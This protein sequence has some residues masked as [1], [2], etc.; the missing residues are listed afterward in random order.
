MDNNKNKNKLILKASAGT[1]K[2]YRLSLEYVYNLCIGVNYKNILVMTFTK[3]ATAEIKERILEFL[4]DISFETKKSKDIEQKLKEFHS[5]INIDRE[6]LNVIYRE[7]IKNK[8]RLKIYT[9][10][11]FS[12][13]IFKDAIT[14]YLK[15]YDYE[16]IDD[17]ENEKIIEKVL[18]KLFKF[19]F[20]LVKEF[21][22]SKEEKYS[23]KYIN[24]LN[25]LIEDRWKYIMLKETLKVKE[26]KYPV[27][28]IIENKNLLDKFGMVLEVLHDIIE[29]KRKDYNESLSSDT[30]IR[31]CIDLY[32]TDG[33]DSKKHSAILD[34]YKV[35]LSKNIWNGTK[36]RS[37]KDVPLE[38]L[39]EEYEE[40]RNVLSKEVFNSKVIPLEANIFMFIEKIYE[41][42]DEIKFKEKKFTFSDISCYTFMYL[43]DEKLNFVKDSK[44][45]SDFF[46]ILSDKITTIFIDE[47]QD[48][49]ILQ[50][51]I[52]SK[53]INTC[54]NVL[55]V[56]D[57]K[58]SI[59]G[60]RGGEK[61]L[62]ENL[63]N[64]VGAKVENLDTCYRSKENI[65]NYCN[66]LFSNLS[67]NGDLNTFFKL[68]RKLEWKFSNIKVKSNE[69]SDKNYGYIDKIYGD[70]EN[71]GI[72]KLVSY[73]EDNFKKTGN[74]SGIGIISRKN[75]DLKAIGAALEEKGIPYII[76][77]TSNI[78]KNKS[79]AGIYYL[80][81]Y[82]CR[83]EYLMLLNFLTTDIV[84]LSNEELNLVINHNEEIYEYLRNNED[85]E[86]SFNIN[87]DIFKKI[88]SIKEEYYREKG[89]TGEIVYNIVKTFDII[90]NKSSDIDIEN[91][92]K[93]YEL[94]N[95]YKYVSDFIDEIEKNEDDPKFSDILVKEKNV[96][97][98]ITVHKS[99]GLSYN[100]VFYYHNPAK[101]GN[102]F[103]NPLKFMIKLNNEFNHM[104]KYLLTREEYTDVIKRL[105]EYKD[106]VLDGMEVE[107]QEA[108]NVIYVVL[109]RAIDNLILVF[110]G[111]F[112]S[113]D[114]IAEDKAE[115]K[116]KSKIKDPELFQATVESVKNY[117]NDD[118]IFVKI[119]SEN[120]KNINIKNENSN[121]T[122][123]KLDNENENLSFSRKISYKDDRELISELEKSEIE[124][125]D[126]KRMRGIIVHYF[127]ENLK[128]ASD[129]EIK[130]AREM[131]RSKYAMEMGE[132]I[133]D[134]LS[135]DNIDRIISECKKMD[136]FSGWNN[137]LSEYIMFDEDGKESRVD[138]IMVRFPKNGERG[139][140][141]IVDFKTGGHD[142]EQSERY[143]NLVKKE[144]E[145]LENGNSADK[146]KELSKKYDIEFKYVEL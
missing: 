145:N 4:Y 70:S 69:P 106:L 59:Y 88:K 99:K 138:R 49:S 140:I 36:I 94:L 10:D 95:E 87:M 31:R 92:Y 110:E 122:I 103:S 45:T 13:W 129:N 5:D 89:R 81:R 8:D 20:D 61:K 109:T 30:N 80:F 34:K 131:A 90:N 72:S 1:G 93:F 9:I 32:E 14:K 53:I 35:F 101:K 38:D 6:K 142:E 127:L 23:N 102:N 48:T 47:F 128:T 126:Y 39:L 43:N 7:I 15:I 25:K 60:W 116:K 51:Q 146:G 18:E 19:D 97:T 50:W 2:T 42:Y 143:V 124:I 64:I 68:D 78:K 132:S 11:S 75:K 55:C 74:Y 33:N 120:I 27:K 67:E 130:L 65:T 112:S 121:T 98:L 100:T 114:K 123:V 113:D 16:N 111:D 134:I 137:I 26:D 41:Y 115:E 21:L 86:L 22:I 17:K 29:K 56:G 119:D 141:R 46:D 3:K 79:V 77:A 58:Q 108:L 54:D 136:I 66:S 24:S 57:E 117:K 85:Y 135:N 28:N 82:I 44:V 105:D 71:N 107:A 139:L 91:I 40:F 12:N 63:E 144:L 84:N 125:D 73:I 118:N 62:F 52:L 76:E 37:S 104:I 96:V 133:D 83:N